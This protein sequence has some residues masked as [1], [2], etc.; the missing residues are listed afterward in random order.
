MKLLHIDSSILN[1]EMS[2]SRQVS[3]AVVNRLRQVHPD[4][5]VAYRDLAHTPLPHMALTNLVSE[6]P[7]VAATG[8]DALAQDRSVSQAVL[9][10][11]I[12]ADIVVLAAPM[13]NFTIPSQLKAW[14]D[15]V[16]I[17]GKTFRYGPQG[18]VGLA[19]GKRV[20]I[21]VSRGGFYG[22]DTP[23]AS[24][25]L[26]ESYLRA[27]LGFIGIA[28]PHVIVAEGLQMG[29]EQRGAAMEDALQTIAALN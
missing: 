15:R 7:L 4:L 20:I 26:G 10:E 25:E 24:F 3:A 21:A 13:Y 28:D 16:L 27:V 5:H 17:A 2:A 11:F 14:V 19:T 9:N 6:H 1:A 18:L 29:P 22:A 8:G 23:M 12:E